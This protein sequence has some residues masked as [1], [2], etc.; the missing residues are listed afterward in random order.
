MDILQEIIEMDKAAAARADEARETEINRL[1]A[2]DEKSSRR[3][4]KAVANE[5]AQAEAFRAQREQQLTQ[6]R[7]DTKKELD[8]SIARLDEIFD[9]HYEEWQ[10]EIISRIT[11][12]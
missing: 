2:L 12:T 8:E 10:S 3:T 5:K 11:G 4:E 7:S 6:K 9:T 1:N